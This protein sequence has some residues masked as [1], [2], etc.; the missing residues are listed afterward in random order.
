LSMG[1]VQPCLAPSL[2][3]LTAVL[4]GSAHVTWQWVAA[5]AK[6]VSPS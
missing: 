6:M 3:H 1:V 5:G 4:A 2:T